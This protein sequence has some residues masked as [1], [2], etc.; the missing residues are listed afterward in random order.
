MGK[1]GLDASKRQLGKAYCLREELR[2][3]E[4]S[5]FSV[6]LPGRSICLRSFWRR[7][8]RQRRML[9]SNAWE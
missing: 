5:V 8:W 7:S 9:L 6:I 4:Q 3:P 1:Q 2:K